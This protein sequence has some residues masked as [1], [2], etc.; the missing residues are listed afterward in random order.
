M[1]ISF[2]SG[3]LN[4]FVLYAQIIAFFQMRINSRIELPVHVKSA[5]RAILMLY[6][7]FNLQFFS[8]NDLSFCLLRSATVLDLMMFQY[9]TVFFAFLLVLF[10]MLVF[11]FCNIQPI[12]SF[13]RCRVNRLQSSMIH[14]LSAFLVLCF[15]KCAHVSTAVLSYGL[16]R[17]KGQKI[18][19]TVVYLH[20]EYTWFSPAH[21]KYVVPSLTIGLVIVV[22]PL[23]ILLSYPLCFK[24]L[25]AVKMRD[26][27]CILALCKPIEKMKPFLDS[28]QGC[29]KDN[30][31][32]FSGL[33]FLY[34]I[35]ILLN[36]SLN[37]TYYFYIILEAQLILMLLINA[38]IQPYKKR[39]HN[40]IDSLLFANMAMINGISMFNYTQSFSPTVFSKNQHITFV[41]Q[42]ILML[43]PITC[44]VLYYTSHA[45][46]KCLRKIIRKE[47]NNS[48]SDLLDYCELPSSRS[49]EWPVR[50]SGTF[51]AYK[52]F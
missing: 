15:A 10:I 24:C 40:T 21:L 28:F 20:G 47:E 17:G 52:T 48:A 37:L 38:I 18:V 45:A 31:R 43:M 35:L 42:E 6:E 49:E 44:I 36:Y 26:K 7:I 13:F 27:R 30:C 19:R 39:N 50:S 4:G 3:S 8:N 41:V 12:K 25:A 1:N 46:M 51:R 22:I 23:V 32:F 11:R 14:G 34:R 29:Y 9:T 33:Y 5:Y 2:T 16:I